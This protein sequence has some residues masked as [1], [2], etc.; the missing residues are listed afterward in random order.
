M[1]SELT[2]YVDEKLRE[3]GIVVDRAT[4]DAVAQ[5]LEFQRS[6]LDR[7]WSKELGEVDTMLRPVTW[8]RS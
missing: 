8:G 6:Q 1:S 7:L 2:R 5:D 3:R 4:V